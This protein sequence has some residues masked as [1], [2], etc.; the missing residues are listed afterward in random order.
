[1]ADKPW[2]DPVTGDLLFDDYVQ[3]LSS[4]KQVIADSVITQVEV[5]D[6][7][8]RV[9]ALFRQLERKLTPEVRDIAT[10]ALC[11]LAVLV[12]LQLRLVTVGR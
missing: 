4:F 1:M 8:E 5:D 12:E 3:D 9:V 11:E 2:F 10:E 7:E 6:Q